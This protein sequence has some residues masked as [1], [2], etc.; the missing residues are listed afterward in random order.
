MSWS[1]CDSLCD[2]CLSAAV[3]Y[4]LRTPIGLKLADLIAGAFILAPELLDVEVLSVLRRA[5]LRQQLAEQ[6]AWLALEDLLVWPIDRLAHTVLIREAWQHRHN[7]SA[8]DA[9]YVAAARLYDASLL[10]TDGPL[11]RAPALGIVVQNIRMA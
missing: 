3:E 1:C 5:V 2:R 10:T 6:R 9:F 11:A 4:L 8:Y 7:V